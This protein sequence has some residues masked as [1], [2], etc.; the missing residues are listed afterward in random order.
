MKKKMV[1]N[2]A[3]AVIGTAFAAGSAFAAPLNTNR[4]FDNGLLVGDIG[5]QDSVQE[6]MDATFGV[7]EFNAIDDQNTAAIWTSAEANVD[8][9][10]VTMLN[11]VDTNGG[12]YSYLT[13]TEYQFDNTKTTVSFS[14]NDAGDLYVGGTLAL[15][16]FGDSFGFWVQNDFDFMKFYTE[17]DKNR[18]NEVHALTYLLDSGTT[19]YLPLLY[20]GSTINLTGDD[21]WMVAFEDWAVSGD[22]NDMVFII[23]DVN[24]V[25][26]PATMFLFGTGLAGFAAMRRRKRNA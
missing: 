26:E 16:G 12:I 25:P 5:A 21:D 9:Y 15:T 11:T 3:L 17:D 2:L 22:F 14:I 20:G 18:D 24:A 8:T 6:I 19:A 23:E 1:K 10:L 7:G 4:P 13:G